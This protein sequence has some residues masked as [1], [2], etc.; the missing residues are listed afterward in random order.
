MSGE[1]DDSTVFNLHRFVDVS[2]W[3]FLLSSIMVLLLACSFCWSGTSRHPEGHAARLAMLV[4][5]M[6]LPMV[7]P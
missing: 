1:A 5:T 6:V 2:W 4:S 7:L 3:L